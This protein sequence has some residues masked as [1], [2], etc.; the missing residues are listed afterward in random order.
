MNPLVAARADEQTARTYW[1]MGRVDSERAFVA[2]RRHSRRVRRWRV[3]VPGVVIAA[4][5]LLVLWTWLNP[6][7]M[8]ERLPVKLGDTVISG[9]KITMQQP[10]LSGFTHDSRPYELTATS[11]A[12]DVTRPDL[13]ELR[14]IR[15]KLQTPDKGTTEMTARN[16]VYDS[17]K[18]VITL[19]D[20]VYLVT[21]AYK[22]WLSNAVVD[23]R[24]SNVATDKPVK[25]QMLQGMLNA[26]RLQ[27]TESGDL[28][29]FDG[30]VV[31]DLKLDSAKPREGAVA[32]EPAPVQDRAP[33]AP[34]TAVPR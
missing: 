5:G 19:G 6:M 31:M 26:N 32:Q 2:A 18:E 22:A 30:G 23:I 27:V 14:D 20:D 3:V 10:R 7:R 21:S 11:A 1:T 34:K 28:M 12:Q 33:A 9:T 29:S 8:L 13:I 25:V 15:A 4:L 16:G 17:K 24:T